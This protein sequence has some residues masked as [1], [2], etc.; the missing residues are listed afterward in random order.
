[1]KNNAYIL[2]NK[3]FNELEIVE[4]IS[5]LRNNRIKYCIISLLK[6]KKVKGKSNIIIKSQK[7]L[8][9]I[10]FSKDDVIITSSD[11][12]NEIKKVLQKKGVK[13]KILYPVKNVNEFIK[14]ILKVEFRKQN[15]KLNIDNNFIDKEEY[16]KVVN[17]YDKILRLS[18]NEI[19]GLEYIIDMYE[20][21]LEFNRKELLNADK[22]MKATE[23][24]L[25]YNRKEMIE[26]DKTLKA[27]ENII[28][29]NRNKRI[30][31]NQTEEALKNVIEYNRDKR[32]DEDK[33]DKAL[34]LVR[35]LTREELTQAYKEIQQKSEQ[36]N[37]LKQKKKKIT[38]NN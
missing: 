13:N 23:N 28:E 27:N 38:E 34:D 32:I 8:K 31:I 25:E 37:K 30:E 20:N 22:T 5:L 12:V 36:I 11:N 35:E 3:G 2:L 24:V 14:N 6:K 17:S 29:Y 10:I 15:I 7:L 19:E 4:I 16:D 1:M 26:T 9:N 33:T 18:E 21:I